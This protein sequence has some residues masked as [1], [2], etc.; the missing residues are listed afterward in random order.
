[1]LASAVTLERPA[2]AT[3]AFRIAALV[4]FPHHLVALL[5]AVLIAGSSRSR[6]STSSSSSSSSSSGSDR[7]V[8]VAVHNA[9]GEGAEDGR[10][11]VV[12]LSH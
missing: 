7:E 1:L 6:S 11:D 2:S 5:V 8:E 4:P 3:T 10:V 9:H 12:R